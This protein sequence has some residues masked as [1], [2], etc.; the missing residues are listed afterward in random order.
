MAKRITYVCGECGSNNVF[1]D[2]WAAWD[3]DKQE[4][5][6]DHV[7]TTEFCEDCYGETAFV[8]VELRRRPLA[9]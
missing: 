5:V 1:V 8:E 3:A 2:G 9:A 7:S 6:L 4:W